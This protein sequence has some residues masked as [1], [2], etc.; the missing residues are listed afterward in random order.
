VSAQHTH[1]VV[2]PVGDRRSAWW[3]L[4]E[5]GRRL[6]H[7]LADPNATDDERLAVVMAASRGTYDEVEATGYVERPLELPAPWVERY[8]DQSGGWR[9][10]PPL[11]VEQLAALRP[12]A[13]LVLIPRRQAK[14]LNAG[15]DFLGEAAE[16]VLHPDDAG[17]AGV[18]DGDPVVVRTDRGELT[19]VAK[20]DP[21][22]RRG[23]V[24]IPHG[25]H[26]ANVNAL[27]DKDDV[28]R[29]TGMVRYAGVPVSVSPAVTA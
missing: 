23:V 5:I 22:I 16:V 18:T 11:L 7:D 14:K 4:A 6:G 24:S 1:P 27:T 17:G 12:P 2:G 15:L 21:D 3:V 20:V 26:A 25:H 9:L 29:L 28:D 8:L 10:A 19:G 13:P